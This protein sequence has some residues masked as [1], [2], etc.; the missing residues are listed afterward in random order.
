MAIE[1]FPLLHATMSNTEAE[2]L[3]CSSASIME[4]PRLYTEQSVWHENITPL[5]KVVTEF[6][7]MHQRCL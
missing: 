6:W 5:L 2:V 1:L 3:L 7:T 4:G